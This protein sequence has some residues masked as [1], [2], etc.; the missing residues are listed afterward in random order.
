MKLLNRSAITLL[1]RAPFAEWIA[2]LPLEP[3]VTNEH[4]SLEQLRK[5]GNVYLIDEVDEEADFNKFMHSSWEIIFKNELT[6]WDEFRDHW[7]ENL[8]YELFLQW[9]EYAN[10]I[11]AFDVSDEVLLVAPLDNLAE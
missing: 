2:A 5:E 8:S 6:A 9:F 11:M 7:P 10:Q 1:A 4:L 3:G